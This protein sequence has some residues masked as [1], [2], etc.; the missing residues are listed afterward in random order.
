MCTYIIKSLLAS[1]GADDPGSV[2]SID[3]EQVAVVKAQITAWLASL[4]KGELAVGLNLDG[5]P[6]SGAAWSGDGGV[7]VAVNQRELGVL[8]LAGAFVDEEVVVI[9][10]GLDEA[11]R[12][13]FGELGRVGDLVLLSRGDE[14]EG[15]G[16]GIASDESL[17]RGTVHERT[18]GGGGDKGQGQEV[19]EMHVAEVDLT[20]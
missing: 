4:G 20:G 15:F 19:G 8:G 13:N 16:N 18:G 11:E 1:F 2:R 6:V 5:F 17:G 12:K 14:V 7:Q 3:G 9:A 10:G